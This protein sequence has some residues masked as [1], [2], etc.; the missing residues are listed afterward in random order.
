MADKYYNGSVGTDI[1][2]DVGENITGGTNLKLKVK[3]PDGSLVEWIPTVYNSNYLKYT[4]TTD[5]WNQSGVYKLHSYLT[6]GS[7]TG[8]GDMV[9]FTVTSNYK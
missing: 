9:E 8:H 7:W 4:I 3:K 2:V 6:I 1:I 5:D